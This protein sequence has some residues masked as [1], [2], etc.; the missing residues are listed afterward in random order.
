[1]NDCFYKYKN[2]KEWFRA[3]QVQIE[4]VPKLGFTYW[5]LGFYVGEFNE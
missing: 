3:T 5:F 2:D 4:R 1:M